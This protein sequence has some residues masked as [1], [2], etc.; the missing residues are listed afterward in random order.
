MALAKI[1]SETISN[2]IVERAR[3][4]TSTGGLAPSLCPTNSLIITKKIAVRMVIHVKSPK[5]R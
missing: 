4:S 2:E 1:S 5:V 3:L